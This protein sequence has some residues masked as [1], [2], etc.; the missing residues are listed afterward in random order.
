MRHSINNTVPSGHRL[1]SSE[2]WSLAQEM[3]GRPDP[4]AL[5]RVAS[6]GRA[7]QVAFSSGG[8]K[9]PISVAQL[10]TDLWCCRRGNG[11]VLTPTGGDSLSLRCQGARNGTSN[12][13][14]NL[15]AA[16]ERIDLADTRTQT[17]QEPGQSAVSWLFPAFPNKHAMSQLLRLR[18]ISKCQ[19]IVGRRRRAICAKQRMAEQERD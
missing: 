19:A 5:E 17:I 2:S 7:M 15:C 3:Q 12:A 16:V 10:K 9:L 13:V 1:S 8:T 4:D 6:Q 18:S 14:R 11:Q